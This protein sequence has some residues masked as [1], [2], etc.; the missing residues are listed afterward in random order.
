MSYKPSPV[1]RRYLLFQLPG[2]G[3]AIVVLAGLVEFWELPV[4][5]AVL[6]LALWVA[7]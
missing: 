4:V 2:L 3:I 6:L 5:A 1:F 7:N